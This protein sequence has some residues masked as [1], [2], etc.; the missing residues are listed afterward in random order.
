MELHSYKRVIEGTNSLIAHYNLI[1]DLTGENFNVFRILKLESSEVKLHSAFLAELLNPKGTHGQK[2][3]FLKLFI[4]LFCFKG[5]QIETNNC[6]A[7]VELHT[8]FIKEDGTEGGRIDIIITDAHNHQIIIENKIYAG[9]QNKQLFRYHT[10]NNK[11]DIFYLTL[12]GKSP[13]IESTVN[14]KEDVD[15]KCLSYKYSIIEW[16]EA[17]RKEVTIY[18]I[19]R[20]S[21]T[22]YINLIKYLTNQTINHAMEKELSILLKQNI[23]ASFIIK[24]NLTSALNEILSEYTYHL[25]QICEPLGL[26]C[27][28]KVD[29]KERYT[30][31]WIWKDEWAYASIGFQFQNYNKEL[32]Y[33][34]CVEDPNN[35]PANLRSQINSLPNNTAQINAWWPWYRTMEIPYNDWGKFE[36]WKAIEDGTMAK[37]MKQKI[38]ML[39]KITADI[40]L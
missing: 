8:G 12:D 17:C 25:E 31:F 29:F 9:D 21:I 2:D 3:T 34:I 19:V 13:S 30:G 27:E 11:A 20:E 10:F 40:K 7:D 24:E 37:N 38:E 6:K 39:L 14:L 23:E 32:R 36:A 16:L 15:F 35:F 5:N 22:Q 4:D 28:N 18:P 1:S 26:K 33:G